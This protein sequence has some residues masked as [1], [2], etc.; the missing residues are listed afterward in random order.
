MATP[1]NHS[2]TE[3]LF[4][5]AVALHENEQYQDAKKMYLQALALDPASEDIKYNLA[6]V[7]FSLEDYESVI[8]LIQEIKEIDC[9]EIIAEL[10]NLATD[11]PVD[12]PESIP[13]ACAECPY[14]TMT[15][16][17][18]KSRGHCAFYQ[19]DCVPEARCHAWDL[20][21]EGVLDTDALESRR[22]LHLADALEALQNNLNDQTLPPHVQCAHCGADLSL[23]ETE[24]QTRRYT[25][26]QCKKVA[27]IGQDA[28]ALSAQIHDE[29]D[30]VL[31]DMV[32]RP[33]QFQDAFVLAAKAE[34]L[35]RHGE[36]KTSETLLALLKNSLRFKAE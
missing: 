32:T 31:F 35:H 23:S 6:L 16:M 17:R 30:E 2:H 22:N 4:D 20:A 9:S 28:K 36:V 33:D 29:S 5:R 34:L 18:K 12:I 15:T 3:V 8:K 24:Q 7:Y 26:P 27:E 25:C 11:L 14:F 1:S 10:E 13:D 19:I 21:D